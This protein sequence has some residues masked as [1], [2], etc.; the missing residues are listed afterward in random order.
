MDK[1]YIV[2]RK[3]LPQGLQLA[4]AVHAG[5]AFPDAVTSDENVVVL[6]AESERHLWKLTAQAL[7]AGNRAI[8]F[9]EPDLDNA[10]TAASFDGRSK[11]LLRK[12]PLAFK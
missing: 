5:R 8:Y 1:L 12:L 11:H 7:T 2:V 6:H 10:L 3:D 9:E 4:Q